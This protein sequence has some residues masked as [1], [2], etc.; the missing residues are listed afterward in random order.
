MDSLAALI[1]AGGTSRRLAGV[2]KCA[3][4]VGD[5]PIID[6]VIAA[7]MPWV[8]HSPDR[9]VVVGPDRPTRERTSRAREDPPGSGPL[10]GIAAGLAAADRIAGAGDPRV[11][12]ESAS[13]RILLLAGDIPFPGPGLEVLL[14]GGAAAD[15]EAVLGC[16]DRGRD[17]FLFAIWR[18]DSLRTALA[19]RQGSDPL[20]LL[21]DGPLIER[22]ELPAVSTID[23]DTAEDLARARTLADTGWS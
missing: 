16:D 14:G 18:T 15:A 23:C 4:R 5:L 17:Q 22:R 12:P 2:D 21:Y 13:S 1:L 3:V 6:R 7:V 11:N 10:A 19:R 20:R 9:V 8:D